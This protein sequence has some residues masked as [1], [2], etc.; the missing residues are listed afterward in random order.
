MR[1]RII[2]AV[3]ILAIAAVGAAI[4]FAVPRLPD[5]GAAIPTAKVV[6]GPLSLTVHATGTDCGRKQTRSSHA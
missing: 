3:V 2:T 1:R 5:R 6:K 4:V